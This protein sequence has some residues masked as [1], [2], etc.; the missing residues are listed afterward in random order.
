M[1]IL[2]GHV[3]TGSAVWI[4]AAAFLVLVTA[5]PAQAALFLIFEGRGFTAAQST[6]ANT[7]GIGAPGE[8]IVARTGGRNAMGNTESMRAFMMPTGDLREVPDQVRS[9][10][11]LRSTEALVPLGRIVADPRGNGHLEFRVPEEEPGRYR[12]LVYCP[13]CAAYSAGRNVL[14]VAAFRV[15]AAS[16]LATTGISHSVWIATGVLAIALGAFFTW[17]DRVRRLSRP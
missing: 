3:S 16:R 1:R 9:L 17:H 6:V 10:V 12:I 2:K 11:S 7:G 15:L 13:D 4:G 14:P 5:T 8:R